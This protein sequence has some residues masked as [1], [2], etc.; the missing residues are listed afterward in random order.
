MKVFLY[1]KKFRGE[2]KMGKKG[3]ARYQGFIRRLNSGFGYVPI[4]CRYCADKLVFR[5]IE[6]EFLGSVICPKCGKVKKL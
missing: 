6:H 4:R 2:K 1:K 5:M 3:S